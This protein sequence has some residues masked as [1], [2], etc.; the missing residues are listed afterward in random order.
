MDDQSNL[1]EEPEAFRPKW[2]DGE[3]A[4]KP[5]ETIRADGNQPNFYSVD[6][7]ER[8]ARGRADW[9]AQSM[10][11]RIE[12]AWRGAKCVME[13]G[14]KL[15]AANGIM[16]CAAYV[17]VHLDRLG[18]LYV[19]LT[20][21]VRMLCRTLP[22]KIW[23]NRQNQQGRCTSICIWAV[24]ADIRTLRR[25]DTKNPVPTTLQRR[26][27]GHIGRYVEDCVRSYLD[28]WPDFRAY[29]EQLKGQAATERASLRGTFFEVCRSAPLVKEMDNASDQLQGGDLAMSGIEVKSA[30]ASDHSP[31]LLYELAENN[32]N[33]YTSRYSDSKD[34]FVPPKV[35]IP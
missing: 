11:P 1:F 33:K 16:Q 25:F 17:Y 7:G 26:G 20:D 24:K 34:R 9:Y 4:P 14:E 18:V 35:F 29:V 31:Y 5:R 30:L 13:R 3:P 19:S 21:E 28:R 15:Y 32:D 6:Q 27:P 22:F 8:K 23:L 10:D 2:M 12:D